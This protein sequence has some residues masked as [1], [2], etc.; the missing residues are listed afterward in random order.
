MNPVN[1]THVPAVD[2]VIVC[3]RSRNHIA[4]CL[5][6]VFGQAHVVPNVVVI[7]NASGDGVAECLTPFR[8][9]L[10]FIENPENVGFGRACNQGAAAGAAPFILFLNPDCVMA[11][12]AVAELVEFLSQTP[13]V[14]LA[15]PRILEPGGE[16]LPYFAYPCPPL[17]PAHF[18]KLP[19]TITSIIGACMIV[20]RGAFQAADGFDPD[21]PLYAEETDLCLRLRMAGWEIGH[22]PKAVVHHE[23]GVS[24]RGASGYDVERRKRSALLKF[25]LKHYDRAAVQKW[26]RRERARTRLKTSLYRLVGSE[27][28]IQKYRATADAITEV[29]GS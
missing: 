20:R 23:H 13:P 12:G 10:T 14:A 3:Y 21:F 7:E 11:D 26:A 8:D 24:E 18:K 6:S 1:S 9:K 27:T 29:L 28:K 4:K 5:V 2:V 15:G 25:M 22:D 17:A 16:V 19:G